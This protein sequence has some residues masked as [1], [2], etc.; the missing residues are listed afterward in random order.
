MAYPSRCQLMS[1]HVTNDPL[2][3]R[4]PLAVAFDPRRIATICFDDGSWD[5]C[6]ECND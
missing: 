6:Y 3:W 1:V 4:V 5:I 2:V